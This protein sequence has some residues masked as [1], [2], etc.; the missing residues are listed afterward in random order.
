VALAL[1]WQESGA[2]SP[3]QETLFL[4]RWLA[5]ALKQRRFSRDVTP[6][7]EWLLKQ[8][9]QLGASAKLASKL[10]Y[11]WRSCS[12]ELTEQNDRKITVRN[13]SHRWYG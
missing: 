12:G 10:N 1:A 9:R 3:A 13:E 8:G 4:T 7:I 5:N 11:L 2:L 6:D